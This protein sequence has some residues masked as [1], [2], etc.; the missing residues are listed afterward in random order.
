M[1]NSGDRLRRLELSGDK[2]KLEGKGD[3]RNSCKEE[4]QETGGWGGSGG[5]GA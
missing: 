2:G 3:H 1:N 5:G 4:R